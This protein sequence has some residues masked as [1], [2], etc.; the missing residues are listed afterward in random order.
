MVKLIDASYVKE[1]TS[2]YNNTSDKY[3]NTAIETAQMVGL[4]AV[5]GTYF[6]KE[7]EKA[8]EEEKV[9]EKGFETL[10]D[11]YIKP[12]LCWEAVSDLVID[13]SFSISNGGVAQYNTD[14]QLLP[15]KTVIDYIQTHYQNR[16]DFF[17]ERLQSYVCDKFSSYLK[18]ST[19][20][21][22]KPNTYSSE[23][24]GLFLGNRRG[25]L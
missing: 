5:L 13:T 1:H 21:D 6:Y 25:R 3:I 7:V 18:T 12:Y 17:K 2:V 14:N 20:S 22:M 8:V 10:L 23:T 16:A 15:S 9:A 11:E 24:S 19:T 4:Q